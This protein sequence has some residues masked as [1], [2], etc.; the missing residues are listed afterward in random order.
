MDLSQF[1]D[2]G[3]KKAFLRTL[4]FWIMIKEYQQFDLFERK[5][6]ERAIIEPPF[7]I[8]AEMP[9]EACFYYVVEGR[10]RVYTPTEKISTITNEGVV[11]KC[12]NYLNEYFADNDATYCEA[13]AIHFPIDVLKV[14]YDKEFPDFLLN[15][16]K[17]KPVKFKKYS[18]ESVIKNYIE[19]LIFY[20]E[21]PEMVSEELLKLKL[22]ELIILLAKTDNAAQIRVLLEALF[23]KDDLNFREIIEANL[24]NNLSLEELAKLC[25]LSLSTFKREFEK[26]YEMPPATYIRKRKLEKAAQL[27]QGTSLRI[28]DIAFDCGFNDLAHFSRSFQ[29]EYHAS[30][31]EY[32]T[33]F[34]DKSLS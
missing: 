3:G 23:T 1:F 28:S 9:D 29:K 18:S 14:L 33:N 19:S 12:G 11:M 5:I 15:V 24:Y 10:S 8:M 32:R 6:F 17:I 25:N 26:Q 20:F 21:N 13:V 27:L 4:I 16:S 30:P 31:S 34:L 2:V 22:K 7:R